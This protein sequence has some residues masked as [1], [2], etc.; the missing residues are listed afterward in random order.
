MK[1]PKKLRSIFYIL[2]LLSLSHVLFS[3]PHLE[4]LEA[5]HNNKH[6]FSKDDKYFI[7]YWLKPSLIFYKKYVDKK[8]SKYST[9]EVNIAFARRVGKDFETK[10]NHKEFGSRS[11]ID[12]KSDKHARKLYAFKNIYCADKAKKY[13]PVLINFLYFYGKKMKINNKYLGKKGGVLNDKATIRCSN[14][15]LFSLHKNRESQKPCYYFHRIE[16]IVNS[17]DAQQ[18]RQLNLLGIN[19]K[20]I[21]ELGKTSRC[22]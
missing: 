6:Q 5:I 7:N 12:T 3:Q 15:V 8:Y 11:S 14:K 18:I 17:C 9:E 13:I 16:N 20:L 4:I 22:D 10:N 21:E 19:Q 1:A 2:I